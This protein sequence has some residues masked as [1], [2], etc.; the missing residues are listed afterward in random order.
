MEEEMTE[1]F[2]QY[3]KEIAEFVREQLVS[4]DEGAMYLTI[5]AH[6]RV[7]GELEVTYTVGNSIL[8]SKSTKGGSLVPTVLEHIN[9]TN[10]NKANAP[11]CLPR[12]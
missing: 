2:D 1:H 7:H 5:T 6:G 4:Q 9:R 3:V 8:E 10:W 11:L 12:A